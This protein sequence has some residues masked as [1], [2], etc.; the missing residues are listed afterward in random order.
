MLSHPMAVPVHKQLP[1][2]PPKHAALLLIR[3]HQAVHGIQSQHPKQKSTGVLAVPPKKT[4]ACPKIMATR[5]APKPSSFQVFTLKGPSNCQSL[6]CMQ[7]KH[8]PKSARLPQE[9]S[10]RGHAIQQ[11]HSTPTESRRQSAAVPARDDTFRERFCRI[12]EEEVSPPFHGGCDDDNVSMSRSGSTTPKLRKTSAQYASDSQESLSSILNIPLPPSPEEGI[13]SMSRSGSITPKLPKTQTRDSPESRGP[14][15][16][17]ICDIWL[18]GIDQWNQHLNKSRKHRK[19]MQLQAKAQLQQDC[20]QEHGEVL[21]PSVEMQVA[22]LALPDSPEPFSGSETP[23]WD[24]ISDP[25][26]LHHEAQMAESQIGRPG[27][28][29]SGSSSLHGA[30]R[31]RYED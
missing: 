13:V 21:Q 20:L 1:M 29:P 8:V 6:K 3:P 11:L 19:N 25:L 17:D 27:S 16:C 10:H 12:F 7:A 30:K 15:H 28:D 5:T 24:G 2:V 31:K 18:N 14:M 26:Q 22:G 23:L 9:H 4:L